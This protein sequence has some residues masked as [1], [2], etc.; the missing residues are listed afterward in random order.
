VPETRGEWAVFAIG[1]AVIGLLAVSIALKHFD[2]KSSEDPAAAGS[3]YSNRPASTPNR[4]ASSTGATTT[5]RA[6]SEST[7]RLV[8]REDTW[9]LVRRMGAT[10]AVLYEGTLTAGKALRFTG[11]GFRVRFGAASSI[12]AALDGRSLKLPPGTYTATITPSGVGTTSA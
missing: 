8:A 1:V 6:T 7:L 9:V 3:V 2:S 5:S 12:A 11:R 4:P 10:G